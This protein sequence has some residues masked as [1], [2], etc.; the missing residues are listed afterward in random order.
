MN[1]RRRKMMMMGQSEDPTYRLEQPPGQAAPVDGGQGPPGAS[2]QASGS[3]TPPGRFVSLDAYRGCIMTLLAASG[4]GIAAFASLPESAPVWQERDYAF[5]QRLAF[6]FEHPAW[7]SK[8]GLMGV[9]GWDLIQPAF[10][11]M[12]GIAMPFSYARRSAFGHSTARRF[13]HALWRAF[14]LVLLG[15]FLYSLHSERT[16]WIFPNVLAQ[17]GLG[18]IFAY[19]LL[20]RKTGIQLAALAAILIGY[21]YFFWQYSVPEGYDFA[22]VN[23]SLE[24][25]EVFEGRFAPWSKNANAAHAFDVTLLNLLRGPDEEASAAAGATRNAMNWAPAWMVRCFFANPEPFKF[26]S[27]GYQTLN[28]VPS[29]ATALLGIL[30]GQLLLSGRRP[31]AKVG[32]LVGGGALCMVL[33]LLAGEFAC[34]IVKRIWTPSWVLFSGAYVIWL[35]AIFYV[36]FDLL[37]LKPL[38]F[39]LV[40][41]GMNSIAIYLMGELLHDW[42]ADKVVGI[43]LTGLLQTLFGTE[44]LADDMY[45]RLII[46]TAVFAVFW[47]IAYWMYRQR[48]FVRV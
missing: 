6:H 19:A 28:F 27:G 43:H 37:P 8:F 4:F 35:L 39:P 22:A 41:V 10:M 2:L 5:W 34:P 3:Q 15:V 36:L 33:G 44:A 18:Y 30:C 21:W 45:A 25:G 12:V 20:G 46:P 47:L 23:A 40:V 26:N 31:W 17:I 11:F 42:T 13:G 32:W 29:I 24:K 9:S 48:Y 14:V 38:A 1:S 16:N 7:V